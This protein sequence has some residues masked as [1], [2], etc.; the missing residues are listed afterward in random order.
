MKYFGRKIQG[1]NEEIIVIPRA[2][3]DIILKAIAIKNYD[4]FNELVKPP[5]PPKVLKKGQKVDD[6]DNPAYKLSLTQFGE[7]RY[8]FLILETLRHSEGLEWETVDLNNPETWLNWDKELSDSG[9][10]QNE[11]RLITTGVLVANTLDETKVEEARQRFL[12][13]QEEQRL[14]E[15]SQKAEPNSMQSGELANASQ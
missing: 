9:F 8:A 6:F 7:K 11:I 10:S 14:S 4:R 13:L 1:P 5:A 2:D 3:G 15:L 12:A